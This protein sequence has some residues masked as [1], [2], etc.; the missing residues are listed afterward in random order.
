MSTPV[1]IVAALTTISIFVIPSL[2]EPATVLR[3]LFVLAG[4]LFGPFGMV[5]MFFLMLVSICGMHSFGTPYTSPLVPFGRGAVRDGLLRMPWQRLASHPFDV[6]DL[7]GGEQ[8][9]GS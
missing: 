9:Y 4:G 1:L 7:P 6:N 8:R 5:T 2:Y 3:V